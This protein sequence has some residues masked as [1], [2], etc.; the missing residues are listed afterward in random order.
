M[1][2]ETRKK[3]EEAAWK[4]CVMPDGLDPYEQVYFHGIS[5]IFHNYRIKAINADTVKLYQ[6]SLL[7]ECERLQ[8]DVAE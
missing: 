1:T 8:G 4:G 5:F 3:I 2:T 6:E 7:T